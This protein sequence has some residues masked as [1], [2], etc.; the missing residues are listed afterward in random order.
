[1][2]KHK[3]GIRFTLFI[4]LA[5]A[6]ALSLALAACSDPEPTATP[7]PTPTATPTPTPEPTATPTP[8]PTDPPAMEEPTEAPAMDAGDGL[9][10][11]FMDPTTTFQHVVDRISE[12]ETACIE[13]AFGAETLQFMLNFPLLAAGSDPTAAAP[14]LGCMT[15]N[16][17]VLF[18]VAMLDAQAGGWE[19]ETRE[20]ITELGLEHPNAVFLRLGLDAMVDPDSTEETLDFNIQ[21]YECQTDEEK[22]AFTVALWIGLD[23]NA[24]GTGQDIYDLLTESEAQCVSDGLP[25]EQF[26]A[27]MA[28]SPLE[29]TQIGLAVAPCISLDTNLKIFANGIQWAMGGVRDETLSCLEEFGRQNPTFVALL[30][31][32]IEGIQA[33]PAAEFLAITAVGNDQYACMTAEEVLR[34]QQAAGAAMSSA[35]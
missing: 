13:A 11:F 20:C 14:L 31:S 9:R 18:V 26:A 33:M 3:S 29:A 34:V 32:G 8:E 21:I 28:A 7:T 16:N 2:Q 19:P 24:E 22:K 35:P 17:A 1:M 12:A 6:L 25:A 10:G 4:A 27:M 30:A 5:L 23:R 15:P